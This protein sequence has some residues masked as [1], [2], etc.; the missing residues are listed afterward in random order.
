[1]KNLD[2]RDLESSHPSCLPDEIGLEL[3]RP[4]I[5]QMSIARILYFSEPYPT[6]GTISPEM[7][8]LLESVVRMLLSFEER[9]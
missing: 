3:R 8:T 7:R 2:L 6:L 1:M 4:W 5:T 9:V